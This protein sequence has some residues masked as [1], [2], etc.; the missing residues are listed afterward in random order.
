MQEACLENDSTL[1]ASILTRI[2]YIRLE[3]IDSDK[4]TS[5][6]RFGINYGRKNIIVQALRSSYKVFYKR[7]Y[8]A[9]P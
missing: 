7:N 4:H 1:V 2:Y 8:R 9:G 6:L 3:V 5:L